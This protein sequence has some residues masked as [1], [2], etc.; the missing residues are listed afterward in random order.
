M[1]KR[2]SIFVIVLLLLLFVSCNNRVPVK[3]KTIKEE[4]KEETV[5]KEEIDYSKNVYAYM[6]IKNY[7]TIKI[8]L[9]HD[10]APITVEHFVYLIENGYL[11]GTDFIRMQNDFVLQGGANCKD[12]STIKGEFASNGVENNLSHTQGIVSMAR[13]TNPDSASSQFFI[14]L[15]DTYKSSLDG[16]YAAF[17]KVVDGWEVIVNILSNINSDYFTNDYY[18]QAMGFFK[19]NY[20]IKIEK[21]T[22]CNE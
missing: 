17:G 5:V 2:L 15:S 18:G 11:N 14:M 8:E 20:Y 13:A 22:V 16:N 12:E 6:T 10:I 21:V 3:E 4:T 9:Y 1:A 19:E 7:G